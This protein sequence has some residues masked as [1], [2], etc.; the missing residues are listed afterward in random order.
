MKCRSIALSILTAALVSTAGPLVATANDVVEIRLRGRY[1]AEPA[2]V[3]LTI[4]VEPNA[5][6]RR[7]LVEAESAEMYRSSEIT[8]DGAGAERLHLLEF[9]NLSAGD[10]VVSAQVFSS[11]Q[12][13]AMATQ[14]LIVNGAGGR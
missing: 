5:E 11:T 12:M 14:E 9:K 10:Y 3:Q 13:K 7:L 6:N 1:Y 2:T 8:L 4:A